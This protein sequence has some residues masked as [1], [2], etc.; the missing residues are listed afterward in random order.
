MRAGQVLPTV[1]ALAL[2]TGCKV[3]TPNR[4]ERTFLEA[5]KHDITVRNKSEKNP[6]SFTKENFAAGKE[7]YGHYCV[8]C[9]GLDGQSTGVPFANQMSPP[10]PSLASAEV[11]SYTDGQLK[12]IID[13][14]ISPSGMPAS[15]GTLSDDEIWSIV[16]FLRHLPPAG[17]LGEPEVYNH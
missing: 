17:S 10:L 12:W 16:I 1:C 8:V 13:N 7:A 11:Q 9:H 14:G 5:V 3:S 15:K 2:L 6:M 4:F